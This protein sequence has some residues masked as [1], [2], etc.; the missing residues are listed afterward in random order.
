M[1]HAQERT[2]AETLVMP[3]QFAKGVG[4]AR[5]ELLAKLEIRIV[6]DLLYFFPRTYEDFSAPKSIDQLVEGEAASVVGE[7]EEI[8]M[9]NT[10]VG[11]SMLGVLIRQRSQ[12]L[13]AL[14][15][16]QPY[17]RNK[18]EN[19]QRVVF[20]GQAKQNGLR[21]E[22]VHPKIDWLALIKKNH[23]VRSCRSIRSRMA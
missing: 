11:R 15:F 9:V 8:D 19:G 21:W 18:F 13:R 3:V 12:Y 4:P 6:R 22:M 5:A 17:L 7:V 20:S 1:S 2:A 10:G 16:N 23:A 14:W